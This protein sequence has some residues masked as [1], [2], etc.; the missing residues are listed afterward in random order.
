[1]KGLFEI[2]T[3]N[4][5]FMKAVWDISNKCNLKC[6]YCGSNFQKNYNRTFCDIEKIVSNIK[7]IVDEVELFGGEPL[8]LENIE[9]I[10]EKLSLNGIGINI[11]C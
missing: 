9:N 4:V 2:Q 5:N 7:G 1:M 8:I 3:L 11:T 10:L 6:K